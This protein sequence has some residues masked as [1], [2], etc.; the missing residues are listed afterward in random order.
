M[1]ENCMMP[2]PPILAIEDGEAAEDGEVVEVD[3]VAGEDDP[4]K[5]DEKDPGLS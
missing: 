5:P 2:G 1:I 4:A 3:E